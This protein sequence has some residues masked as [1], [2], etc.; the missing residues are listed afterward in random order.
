MVFLD[1]R[2]LVEDRD[3][4]AIYSGGFGSEKSG[5][6]RWCE[7][8]LLVGRCIVGLRML[9]AKPCAEIPSASKN[10]SISI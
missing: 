9:A 7:T 3:S 6:G 5:L 1:L 2:W 4:V 10:E 8:L